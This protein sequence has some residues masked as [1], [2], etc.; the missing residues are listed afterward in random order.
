MSSNELDFGEYI[1]FSVKRRF[2]IITLNR[3]H[4]AN[5]FTIPQLKFLKKAVDMQKEKVDG[6]F[7]ELGLG[8]R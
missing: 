5:S 4:R 2:G 7:S 1:E 8:N 3:V 6:K